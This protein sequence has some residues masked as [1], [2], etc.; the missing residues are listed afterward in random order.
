M[1]VRPLRALLVAQ[2]DRARLEAEF[3]E[4][5]Q[6]KDECGPESFARWFEKFDL[7]LLNFY[8][9]PNPEPRDLVPD[10]YSAPGRFLQSGPPRLPAMRRAS[11]SLLGRRSSGSGSSALFLAAQGSAHANSRG[12]S[13][14]SS[15]SSSVGARAAQ[16]SPWPPLQEF[17]C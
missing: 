1:F 10:R 15:H 17:E 3:N 11:L 4:A 13:H 7:L 16:S 6:G 12:S 5:S 8:P 9:E 2:V 14:S